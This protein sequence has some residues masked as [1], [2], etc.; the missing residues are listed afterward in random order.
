[1]DILYYDST[2]RLAI[3]GDPFFPNDETG[4]EARYP[5]KEVPVL[6]EWKT[7]YA[8]CY[9]EKEISIPE[10]AQSF[11]KPFHGGVYELNF[12]NYVG[13]TRI[14]NVNLSVQNRKISDTLYDSMLGYIADKYADLVFSFNTPVGLEYEKDKPGQDTLYL[15][16]LFLKKYLVDDTPNLD[17]ITGLIL[18]RPHRKVVSETIPCTVDEMDHPDMGLLLSIFSSSGMLVKLPA[19]HPLQSTSAARRLYERTGEPYFP[20]E[21]KKSRKYHTFDTNE[22]R[23][24]R[25]FLQDMLDRLN[26]IESAL[27]DS[28]GTYLNPDIA[29]NID[30]LKQKT[31]YFL[32]DP[33]WND[34]GQMTFVPGQS[35]V[36]QRR[37]GYRHLFRLY[38]LLN[39][40]SRYQFAMKDFRNL[41][42]MKDVPTLFE[43]WCFFIVKDILD[44][45]LKMTGAAPIVTERE[46][47][48]VVLEGIRI[49]YEGDIT[50]LYNA[51]YGGS[52]GLKLNGKV[53]EAADYRPFESYSH[54][55]RPDIVIEKAGG[56]KLILDAKY[57]GRNSVSGFYGE[58][59][60]GTIV[61]YKEEDLDKMHA[62]R[63]AIRDVF[64]AFALY[65]GQKA[66]VFPP[67]RYESPF[68]GVGA[69]ALKPVAGNKAK[70]E[71]VE[72]LTT[73]IDAFLETA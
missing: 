29:K 6:G 50:L 39:L 36:L 17:E 62:Y 25:H 49:H 7:H 5:E 11:L 2:E 64:G 22:N 33:M 20:T 1:M 51:G 60:G 68:E 65:P 57:K 19:S 55:L 73:I 53:D 40:A 32:S 35:T 56:K 23:F 71:H 12:K 41:I 9:G 67:H 43:Y 58:E 38:A 61:K 47:Q 26:P 21:F 37:D 30:Q 45:K 10:S 42:E 69:V 16:Y 48:K 24:V 13:L 31:D 63:D 27:G 3:G 70:P 54:G 15:Q 8:R 52:S 46:T 34:V 59:E 28:S 44:E 18:S 66:I 14:G 72:N 4:I